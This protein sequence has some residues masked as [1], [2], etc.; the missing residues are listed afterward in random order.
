MPTPSYLRLARSDEPASSSK[1]ISGRP[2][3]TLQLT[4]QDNG[5]NSCRRPIRATITSLG[6]LGVRPALAQLSDTVP[7]LEGLLAANKLA[8]QLQAL[9]PA[10]TVPYR[11]LIASGDQRPR[12]ARNAPACRLHF[13]GGRRDATDSS[14]QGAA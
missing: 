14:G 9:E 11:P 10:P 12:G 2:A 8:D 4:S 1:N 7:C 13:G 5:T 3:P 6:S